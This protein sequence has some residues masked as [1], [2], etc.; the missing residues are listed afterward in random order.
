[1][2]SLAACL[3]GLA[4]GCA[5]TGGQGHSDA[6]A[7][8]DKETRTR[9][10]Q[11]VIMPG[12]TLEMV[13]LAAGKPDHVEVLDHTDGSRSE[14]WHYMQT[15]QEYVT[16]ETVG[17]EDHTEFDHSSGTHI[18]YKLPIREKVYH[19]TKRPGFQI[20]VRDG[21]V[22]SVHGSSPEPGDEPSRE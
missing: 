10:K 8:L 13:Q 1:M 16:E 19:N 17:Y 9:I 12:D 22:I 11:G 18:H 4:S 2:G 7:A 3:L 21:Y 15:V 6:Y 5:H 14:I 20:L